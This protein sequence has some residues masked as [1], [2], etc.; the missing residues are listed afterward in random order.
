MSCSCGQMLEAS[1]QIM[2]T[3]CFVSLGFNSGTKNTKGNFWSDAT[4]I[5]P[6]RSSCQYHRSQISLN[7]DFTGIH[8]VGILFSIKFCEKWY[9]DEISWTTFQNFTLNKFTKACIPLKWIFSE[10]CDLWYLHD[11]FLCQMLE[12]SDQKTNVG[13]YPYISN[14]TLFVYTQLLYSYFYRHLHFFIDAFQKVS[15]VRQVQSWLFWQ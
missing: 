1:D 5:W 8:A 9:I 14:A 6:M 7:I 13:I 10:I 12:A 4:S 11:L 3:V 15:T 2:P